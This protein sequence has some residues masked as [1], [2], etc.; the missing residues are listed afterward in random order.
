MNRTI[1]AIS[2]T[3][4]GSALNFGSRFCNEDKSANW[5][6]ATS[7][8]PRELKM[9]LSTLLWAPAFCFAP[10][11]AT[12]KAVCTASIFRRLFVCCSNLPNFARFFRPIFE[13]FSNFLPLRTFVKDARSTQT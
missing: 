7:A 8:L 13:F 11:S 9:F 6:S 10:A 2:L 12:L 5:I 3:I 1:N 4:T